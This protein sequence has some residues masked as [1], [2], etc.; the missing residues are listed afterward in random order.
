MSELA[1]LSYNIE[2]FE[3]IVRLIEQKLQYDFEY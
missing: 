3:C 2:D 1:E